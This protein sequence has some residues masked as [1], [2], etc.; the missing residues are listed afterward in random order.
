MWYI[1]ELLGVRKDQVDSV[2]EDTLLRYNLKEHEFKTANDLSGGNKRKLT[3]AMALLGNPDVMIV[4]EVS[5]GVDPVARRLIWKAMKHD[6]HD[7]ALLLTTH[8][9]EEA[10]ALA[11]KIGIM[12]QGKLKCLG[13]LQQIQTTYGSG[14]EIEINLRV[15]D[16]QKEL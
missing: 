12:A 11:N 2:I 14:F 1:C 3:C 7:S 16:L 10:E 4:D 5:A 9:L 15:S 8:T 13:T 6:A